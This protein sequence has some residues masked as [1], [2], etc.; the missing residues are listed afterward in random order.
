MSTLLIH[1]WSNYV[2][3]QSHPSRGICLD[4]IWS[5]SAVWQSPLTRDVCLDH[6]WSKFAVRQSPPMR[7]TF[8]TTFGQSLLHDK[9]LQWGAQF[10]PHL[11]KV[12]CVTK[13]W[14]T[15]GWSLLYGKVLQQGAYVWTT[16]GWSPQWDKV[17]KQRAHFGPHLVKARCVTKSSNKGHNSGHIWSKSAAWQSPLMRG[18][19][20]ATFGQSLLC[21]KV[22]WWGAQFGP[23]LVEVRSETKS[24][25]EG[26]HCFATFG[27]R[28][29]RDNFVWWPIIGIVLWPH[30]TKVS[31]V[32]D[33]SSDKRHCFPFYARF[34][35]RQLIDMQ[36]SSVIVHFFLNAYSMSVPANTTYMASFPKSPNIMGAPNQVIKFDNFLDRLIGGIKANTISAIGTINPGLLCTQYLYAPQIHFNLAGNL[37]AFIGNLSN[38]MGKFS[39]IKIDVPSIC[40]FPYIKDK[41]TMED[42]L[43]P[44]RCLA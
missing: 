34:G 37:M 32:C 43:T 19:I 22:L 15:F 40:L 30:L 26:H 16:F 6:I 7:G 17:L 36:L 18:T 28:P 9:V 24:S 11:V 8:W 23:H 41:A 12:R 25:D 33:T 13:S 4:H 31:C 14:T 39:L 20:W 3:K 42:S 1:M 2:A 29:L 27:H 38:K 10:G 35:Q 21:D 44:W 5:K